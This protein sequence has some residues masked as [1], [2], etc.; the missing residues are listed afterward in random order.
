MS[1]AR[2]IL[3]A[4]YA[5]FINTKLAADIVVELEEIWK[6]NRKH[7]RNA[8]VEE[9]VTS[10]LYNFSKVSTVVESLVCWDEKEELVLYLFMY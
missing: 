2:K 3:R 6:Y 10:M 4:R 7:V 5:D 1:I 8:E 9:L